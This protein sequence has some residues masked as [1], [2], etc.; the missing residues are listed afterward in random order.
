[1]SGLTDHNAILAS[2]VPMVQADAVGRTG[3]R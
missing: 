2:F 3:S 1:M